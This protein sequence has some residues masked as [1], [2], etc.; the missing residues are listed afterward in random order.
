MKPCKECNKNIALTWRRICIYCHNKNELD[1]AKEYKRREREKAKAK[2]EKVI[3]RKK[4]LKDRKQNSIPTLKK[5]LWKIVSEYI[6]R[7]YADQNWNAKCVTCWCVKHWKE[8]QAWHFVPAG[9]S[10]YLRFVET[11]IHPQ[12]YGCNVWKHGNLIEY[13]IFMDNTYWEEYVDLLIQ[14]RNE[15]MKFTTE[16]LNNIISD[17]QEKLNN[18]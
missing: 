14:Q 4:V 16:S 7:K 5:K 17:Y 8:L 2:K 9:S 15:L 1:K 3:E 18:L 11:N 6:R 10:N 13:R 12:C